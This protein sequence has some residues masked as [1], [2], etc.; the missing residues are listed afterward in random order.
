MSDNAR[1][2]NLLLEE[3]EEDAYAKDGPGL[4]LDQRISIASIRSA[5]ANAEAIKVQSEVQ[6]RATA[7]AEALVAQQA[8]FLKP[9]ESAPSEE[10]AATPNPESEAR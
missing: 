6:A 4:T 2:A 8:A 1:E 10:P 5:L 7:A 9:Q 3:I